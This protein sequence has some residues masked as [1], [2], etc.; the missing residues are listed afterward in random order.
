MPQLRWILLFVFTVVFPSTSV[1]D[2]IVGAQTCG[3]SQCHQASKP[4]AFSLVEQTEFFAWLDSPHAKSQATLKGPAAREIASRYGVTPDSQS[5]LTCHAFEQHHNVKSP[6]PTEGISCEACHGS[7]VKWLPIHVSGRSSHQKNLRNG[8]RKLE[9]PSIRAAVC[10]DC[11]QARGNPRMPHKLF[12]AGHPVL[13][14]ELVSASAATANHYRV[15]EDYLVRKGQPLHAEM[16][17]AGQLQ[18]AVSQ[19]K[20]LLATLQDHNTMLPE[21][22]LFECASCHQQANGHSNR[23]SLPRLATS[24]FTMAALAISADNAAL[25]QRW[26]SQIES[27]V[28]LLKQQPRKAATLADKLLQSVEQAQE[29][30]ADQFVK[31]EQTSACLL[32]YAETKTVDADWVLL[33]L[34]GLDTLSAVSHAEQPKISPQLKPLINQHRSAHNPRAPLEQASALARQIAADIRKQWQLEPCA[35]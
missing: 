10:A 24:Q 1:A 11:H 31:P 19:L 23:E 4:R 34:H 9:Q 33:A 32:E 17:R 15:D 6:K 14:F 27:L 13:D 29:Q 30:Y 7:A 2:K 26:L 28:A 21:L 12:A 3:N 18:A 20:G 22:S 8:M 16:W 5:C 25:S 35:R